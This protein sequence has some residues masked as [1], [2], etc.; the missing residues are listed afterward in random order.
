M[1][2]SLAVLENRAKSYPSLQQMRRVE[3]SAGFGLNVVVLVMGRAVGRHWP[4]A[5]QPGQQAHR[6]REGPGVRLLGLVGKS[7]LRW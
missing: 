3:K 2:T 6:R 4:G 5:V 7:R 1:R